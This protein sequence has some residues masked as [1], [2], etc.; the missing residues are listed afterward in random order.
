M[1][2]EDLD[3]AL[4]DLGDRNVERAAPEVVDQQPFHLGRGAGRRSRAAAVGSLMIRT[5]SSSASSPASRR[6]RPLALGEEGGDGDD[7][8]L[9][10]G[11]PRAFSARCWSVRRMMAEISWGEYDLSPSGTISSRPIFRL[12]ERTVRSGASIDWFRAEV[13]DEQP[14]LR[15]EADDRREDRF[16]LL[17]EHDRSAVADHR[18][19]AVGRPEV[20]ADDDVH[21]NS[22]LGCEFAEM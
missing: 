4:L 21:G 20:D 3:D 22:R 16:A 6:R 10:L 7:R 11:W 8:F 13:A 18:H 19:L 17:L 2:G 15:V 12:I 9:H 1:A 5:T 14:S